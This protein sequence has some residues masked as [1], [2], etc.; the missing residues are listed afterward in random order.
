MNILIFTFNSLS[1]IKLYNSV[2]IEYRDTKIQMSGYGIIKKELVIMPR[3]AV[4]IQ[5]QYSIY[6]LFYI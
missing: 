1:F 6:L 3:F 5:Y 4:D 2:I